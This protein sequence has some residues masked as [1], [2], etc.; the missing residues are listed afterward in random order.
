VELAGLSLAPEEFPNL[1]ASAG[2]LADVWLSD[3]DR[4]WR[5]TVDLIT[6]GLER[7]LDGSRRG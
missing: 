4:W 1:V 5:E 6:F 7:M 2:D 3:P